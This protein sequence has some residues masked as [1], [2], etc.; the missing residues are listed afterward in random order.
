MAREIGVPKQRLSEME[1]G[2]LREFDEDTARAYLT[3]LG[4]L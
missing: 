2:R 3:A 4:I 1:L